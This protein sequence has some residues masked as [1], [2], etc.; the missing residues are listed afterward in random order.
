VYVLQAQPGIL[1]A[2]HSQILK[3]LRLLDSGY[4]D[5]CKEF[6]VSDEVVRFPSSEV[7]DAAL[8]E[9]VAATVIAFDAINSGKSN[10]TSYVA[11]SDDDETALEQMMMPQLT[12]IEGWESAAVNGGKDAKASTVCKVGLAYFEAIEATSIAKR[13]PL[14][15][16]YL[17]P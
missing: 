10:P 14:I 9:L 13:P 4:P 2:L 3:A 8:T 7:S 11:P 15:V 12:S 1:I 6:L 5:A 16:T 17:A